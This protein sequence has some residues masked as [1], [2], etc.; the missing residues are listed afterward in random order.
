[1]IEP[2]R[3]PGNHDLF[4]CGNDV[5]A[6]KQVTQLLSEWFGWQPAN[7][8]DLGDIRGARGTE[9]MM[10]FWMRLFQSVIGHPHFNYHIVPGA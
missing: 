1:M 4:I 10:P 2:A 5:A 9:M 8:I 3:V 6:K 7:V